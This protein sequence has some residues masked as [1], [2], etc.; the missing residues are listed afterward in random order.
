MKINHRDTESQRNP[1]K[2][3][4]S[5]GAARHRSCRKHTCPEQQVRGLRHAGCLAPAGSRPE[6]GAR[7]QGRCVPQWL[8]GL[9]RVLRV[10]AVISFALHFVS[11]FTFHES[12]FTKLISLVIIL[13]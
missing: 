6:R 12:L 2:L 13:I 8:K 7:R 4:V 3:S 1:K 10:S 5:P 11:R 9:L